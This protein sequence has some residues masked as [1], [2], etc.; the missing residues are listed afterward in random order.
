MLG[1]FDKDINYLSSCDANSSLHWESLT[2]CRFESVNSTKCSWDSDGT[3]WVWT[4]CKHRCLGSYLWSL[5][6]RR[7]SG[8]KL[9]IEWV[10]CWPIDSVWTLYSQESLG[11]VGVSV[12]NASLFLKQLDNLSA[13]RG[14]VYVFTEPTRLYHPINFQMVL[15]SKRHS[16]GVFLQGPLYV[17]IRQWVELPDFRVEYSASKCIKDLLLI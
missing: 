2:S 3:C 11:Y 17:Q 9:W 7:T 6:S 5:S 10:S 8:N 14:R 1:P 4:K 15:D 16:P 12:G 13:V